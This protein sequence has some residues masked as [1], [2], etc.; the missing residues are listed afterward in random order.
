M[1][2]LFKWAKEAKHIPVDPTEGVKN[3][4]RKKGPGFPVWTE[5][6][7][8]AYEQRWP[9]GTKERV[10]RDVLFYAGLRRGDAV[11]LGRQHIRDGIAALRTEKSQG[12]IIVT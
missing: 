3:P 10:R 2:G 5:E 8:V 1:R 6:D 9:V 4:K 7:A 12:E 11:R